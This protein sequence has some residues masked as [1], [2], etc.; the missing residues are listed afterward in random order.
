MASNAS[1]Y[2]RI[3]PRCYGIAMLHRSII[4]APSGRRKGTGVITGPTHHG[5]TEPVHRSSPE[6]PAS[7]H[8]D[9]GHTS[10]NSSSG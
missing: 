6:M 1:K 4:G 10:I 7:D 2:N 9:A 8:S 5:A 3:V